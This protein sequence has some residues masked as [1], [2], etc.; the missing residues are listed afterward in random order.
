MN[1]FHTGVHPL[2]RELVINWHVTEACNYSCQYCYAKWERQ[3]K[4][5]IHNF[6][7]TQQLLEQIQNYF[8][9]HKDSDGLPFDSLRLNFAGG[10]P[11]LYPD[12]V[13]DAIRIAHQMG[14]RT[15]II[16]NGSR[17]AMPLMVKLAPYLSVL[18]ISLDS[19]CNK[20]NQDIG[21]IDKNLY[22]LEVSNLTG[23]LNEARSIN[24]ALHLK[25]NTVVN[26]LNW[27]EDMNAHIRQIT[28]DKWKVFRMLPSV[29]D[30]L[31]VTDNQFH[32]FVVRHQALEGVMRVEDN[33]DMTESYIMIDPH[34]R[35]FQNANDQKG[36][37]Y[38]SDI[39]DVGVASAFTQITWSPEKFLERYTESNNGVV[40]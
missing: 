11:L 17:L 39:L 35:F 36:Y 33:T 30:A 31:I 19:F 38:S 22:S 27:D 4:E 29:T 16:S 13:L 12:K 34:G 15:S 20:T 10:E 40:A 3:G 9:L 14:M 8:L 24:P 1:F 26:A 5:L 21:R 25:I 6:E 37:Q 18:G 23:I 2:N 7:K 32:S 28:P